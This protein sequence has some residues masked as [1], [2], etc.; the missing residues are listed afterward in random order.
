M[1]SNGESV[2]IFVGPPETPPPASTTTD[3]FL[4]ENE[5]KAIRVLRP[6]IIVAAAV[7]GF[8]I[9]QTMP[10][11]VRVSNGVLTDAKG[12]TL[13]TWDKDKEANKSACVD[14]CLVNWP[15]LAAEG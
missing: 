10:A 7:G 1:A 5:M 9:A 11:S 8:A 15:A 14:N 6:D 4:R 2:V 12:M 13:Y 3:V